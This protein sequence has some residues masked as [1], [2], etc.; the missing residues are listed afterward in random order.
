MN[1]SLKVSSMTIQKTPENVF[2]RVIFN[3]SVIV[4]S[5]ISV[6]FLF[7]SW[8]FTEVFIVLVEI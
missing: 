6:I 3:M 8:E 5:V 1:C 4:E 2:G 7:Y